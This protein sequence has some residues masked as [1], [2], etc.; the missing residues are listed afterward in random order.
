MREYYIR[1]ATH[2]T[3]TPHIIDEEAM[4][5]AERGMNY[6]NP[7]EFMFLCEADCLHDA[8]EQYWEEFSRNMNDA[9][10]ERFHP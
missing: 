5:Q 9:F 10:G 1:I 2:G 4:Y 3:G 6:L 7:D 8:K